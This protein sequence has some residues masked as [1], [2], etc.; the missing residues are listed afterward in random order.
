MK[1][2]MIALIALATTLPTLSAT[3]VVRR[4]TPELRE[5]IRLS[6]L[7]RTGGIVREANSAKGVFAFV[8][9]QKRVPLDEIRHLGTMLDRKMLVLTSFSESQNAGLDTAADAIREAG[10]VVGAVIVEDPKLPML[11]TAPEAGWSVVNVTKIAEG[12]PDE[13][14]VRKRVRRELL[15]AFAFVTGG[16]YLSQAEPLM[17]DVAKPRDLDLLQGDEFGIEMTMGFRERSRNYGLK[18]WNENTYLAACEQGWAPQPTN[19]FQKAIWDKAHQL[20]TNPLPLVK[21][22]K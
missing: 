14:T 16:A 5:K 12:A 18:L 7:R 4:M 20:P 1:K 22:T 21:P 17:R 6:K 10:G 19:E 3:N 11:V 8:N 9:A 13:E 15:R 2:L